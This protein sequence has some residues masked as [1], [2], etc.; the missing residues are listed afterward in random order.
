[1][2]I[3]V[4]PTSAPDGLPARTDSADAAADD[5][6]D[7]ATDDAGALAL[8]IAET[9]AGLGTRTVVARQLVRLLTPALRAETVALYARDE[10][11]ASDDDSPPS[12]RRLAAVVPSVVRDAST[13]ETSARAARTRRCHRAASQA[14][15]RGQLT[16]AT[17]DTGSPET[18][19][20]HIL[21]LPLGAPTPRAALV[22]CWRDAAP[23]PDPRRLS[24]VRQLAPVLHLALGASAADP[25]PTGGPAAARGHAQG[26]PGSA[27]PRLGT[28]FFAAASHELRTPL[29]N[30]NGF[31]ELVL[32]GQAGPLAARQEEFLGL[33]HVST[34]Q[35]TSMV[36]DFLIV[37][38]AGA[39]HAVVRPRRLDIAEA[40]DTAIQAAR[41]VARAAGV[42][43][44]VALP[45]SLPTVSADEMPLVRA[46]SNLL[47]LAI[48]G[49]AA[50]GRVTLLARPEEGQ[51]LL[52]IAP[53]GVLDDRM[54][55]EAAPAVA[56]ETGLETG[57][58]TGGPARPHP[59]SLAFASA[60]TVIEQHHGRLWVEGAPPHGP[61]FFLTLPLAP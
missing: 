49:G 53:A 47:R 26:R 11:P 51:L 38:R 6:T 8:R 18:A 9:A 58:P 61:S 59:S 30:I 46:L 57:G 39:G 12:V 28:E 55:P 41:P 13:R 4:P 43:L 48:A 24:L 56:L 35:L 31:L 10:H 7:D 5:A 40:L 36:E 3:L 50:S 23:E 2:A 33:A 22:V 16:A 42:V 52:A 20:E 54:P 15:A 14:I 45:P 1:M 32:D 27:P 19:V 25:D 17:H 60:R 21:A 44:A 37:C 34:R 29:N